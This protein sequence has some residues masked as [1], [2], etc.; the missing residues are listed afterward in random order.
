MIS[1]YVINLPRRKDRLASFRS[2]IRGCPLDP[3]VIAA[4]DG[5]SLCLTDELKSRIH[6]WNHDH[7]A[8][9][10]LLGLAGCSLS[11]LKLWE[12]IANDSNGY[13]LIF[14]DDARPVN[15]KALSK[16]SVLL[17]RLPRDADLI[18]L[19]G[20][21]NKPLS[22]AK[23]IV[24]RAPSFPLL[25]P[26]KTRVATALENWRYSNEPRFIPWEGQYWYTA[27][28]YIITPKTARNMLAR[29]E[30]TFS[31][32]DNDLLCFA[33]TGHTTVYSSWIPIFEQNKTLTTDIDFV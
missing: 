15:H 16:L 14:E 28:A 23:R 31:S 22:L 24:R 26:A 4:V 30:K 20:P 21:S 7:L 9:D 32:P 17:E 2:A 11:H 27:E 18:W 8:Q 10:K 3:V 25:S 1:S 12:M 6:H 33:K 29:C 19:N 13:H 5:R